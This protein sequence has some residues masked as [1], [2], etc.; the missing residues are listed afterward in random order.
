MWIVTLIIFGPFIYPLVYYFVDY[1]SDRINTIN[2]KKYY[3]EEKLAC[4]ST[5]KNN[6]ITNED[7]MNIFLFHLKKYRLRYFTI[8]YKVF[9]AKEKQ[10]YAWEIKTTKKTYG[11]GFIYNI[12]FHFSN[13][14]VYVSFSN[15][16]FISGEERA[17]EYNSLGY[18]FGSHHIERILENCK[19]ESRIIW[20]SNGK[21]STKYLPF[22][23]FS[24]LNNSNSYKQKKEYT[25]K[26]DTTKT[27]IINF[28]RSLLGLK[29]Q[30]SQEELKK[31]YRE[32]VGKYHPDRYGA[33]SS[34]D[35]EN[36]E[37]LMKQVNE[38]Y[39]ALKGIAA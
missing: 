25:Q 19:E 11:W 27:D 18:N 35:R 8:D 17:M 4:F 20:K 22:N 36:A 10:N 15:S 16:K 37:M 5:Y 39:E 21:Q 38:A 29:I 31:R 3:G 32:A 14:W 2:R 26:E 12:R 28:Y 34:R 33:S 6:N 9:E 1:V 30:F 13:G 7:I 24:L 23:F